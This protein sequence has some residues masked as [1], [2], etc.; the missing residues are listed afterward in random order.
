MWCHGHKRL[1]IAAWI[2]LVVGVQ[3]LS[4]A[5]GK[6]DQAN[7][8]LAGTESQRAYDLLAKHFPVQNGD[9]DQIVFKATSGTLRDP[10]DRSQVNA[11]MA[12]I[13]KDKKIVASVTT[14]F[15]K[16]GQL[17]K[18][19]RIGVGRVNYFKTIDKL[20]AD[21]IKPIQKA[22]FSARSPT[23]E[24]EHG[25]QG[26]ELLRFANSSGPSTGIGFFAA[27]I[28]LL[29]V[30]GSLIAAFLPLITAGVAIGT[31]LGLI[32]LI[33]HVVDTPDFASQLAELIGI[34]VGVDYALFVVTR[35]R[36][37]V[38]NGLS[39]AEAIELAMDTAGRT[40][41]FAACTVVI[42]LLGLLLLG[43]S[44]LHGVAVGAAAA[45]ALTMLA[46][47]TL[48]PALIGGVGAWIDRLRLGRRRKT[49]S[50]RRE[51]VRWERWS[52][53]VQ[54]RPWVA[55]IAG[56][57]IVGGLCVPVFSMR[58]G[59]SDAGVD[60]SGTTTRKAYDV[61]AEGFGPGINGSFLLATK[62]AKPGDTAAAQKVASAAG[63]DRDIAYVGPTSLSPDGAVATVSAYPKTGPQDQRTTDALHRLRDDVMPGVERETGA[64]VSIG[65]NNAAQADFTHVI[66]QKLPLFVGVVVLLS[67]L[68][69]VAMFRSVLIPIKAAVMNLLS[70]GA[71]LGVV[72]AIFQQGFLSNFLGVGEG[73]IEPFLPVL[74]F[75]IVFGLSMDYEVFLIS[76]MHEEWDKSGDPHD[77]VARGLAATGRVITAAAA[78]MVVVFSAFV[79]GDDRI[80]KL[81]GIGLASAVLIDAV[82]IRCL[83]VP[84]IMEL[85]GR[86]AWWLPAGLDRVLPRLAIERAKTPAA[87]TE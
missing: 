56:L 39:R 55:A 70:I 15:Q 14:P 44:F 77:A 34:G 86:R 74:L 35:Y 40:V 62:L 9:S 27:F 64:T 87:A 61:I 68:L 16:G 19:G 45:V 18:D 21:D 59:G 4:G 51:G 29:L 80:I 17:S 2:L 10:A 65:G 71:S 3:I 42:A 26:A 24:V 79:L 8:R 30:F 43:L 84:A 46:A 25:G 23:I 83:L 76:R 32:T 41:F 72:T 48:L 31:T 36:A 73:P 1:T 49:G 33:S 66:A 22:A 81:F 85:F 7:F 78:I 57:A 11:A 63:A 75:A 69:L 67:A 28:I 5:V 52:R 47:I 38:A 60:P 54:R 50:P 13:A 58:L 20:K 82:V 12:A 6:K 37:E 53:A